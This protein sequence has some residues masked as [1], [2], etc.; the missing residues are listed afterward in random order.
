MAVGTLT[1]P[2][3]VNGYANAAMQAGFPAEAAS[4]LDHGP[5]A[6]K[7][8][9]LRASVRKS[10]DADQKSLPKA[11]TDAQKSASGETLV[12]LGMDFYGYGQFDKAI[13]LIQAGIAK[14]GLKSADDTN[15]NLGI[16]YL[17]AGQKDKA[18]ELFKSV[19]QAGG[20]A[21]LAQLWSIKAGS[22]H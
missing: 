2:I 10:Y 8:T 6:G 17:A 5:D 13:A 16:V 19:T 9:P 15:L 18:L 21:E 1:L 11:E 14:G 4:A 20:P 22:V 12:R 7:N 3:Q